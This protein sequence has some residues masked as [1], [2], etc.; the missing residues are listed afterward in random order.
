M[1]HELQIT[2]I[3]ASPI[4]KKGQ[5]RL[6]LQTPDETYFASPRKFKS[7]MSQLLWK[8]SFQVSLDNPSQDRITFKL[9]RK[10]WWWFTTVGYC[11]VPFSDLHLRKEKISNLTLLPP[12]MDRK[13]ATLKIAVKALNFGW[14]QPPAADNRR[15]SFTP[16]YGHPYTTKINPDKGY[17]Y[18]EPPTTHSNHHRSFSWGL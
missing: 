17:V 18:L 15:I 11:S 5:Y 12:K 1:S 9:Q 3:S 4:A 7:R 14:T 16:G 6:K 8:E 10:H 2:I 13:P